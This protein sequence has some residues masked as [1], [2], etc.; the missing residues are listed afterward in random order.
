MRAL[1]WWLVEVW[2]ARQRRR[3]APTGRPP[4]VEI[5]HVRDPDSTCEL[6]VFVDGVPCETA[7]WYD[8]DPGAGHTTA[9]WDRAT[10]WQVNS[11]CPATADLIR[12]VRGEA[13]QSDH[14]R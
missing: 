14:I 13:R 8:T 3:A 7:E 11:A 9:D 4:R 6:F 2:L 12:E 5:V 1:A 10:E